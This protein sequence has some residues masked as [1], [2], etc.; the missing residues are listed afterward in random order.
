MVNATSSSS[1]SGE[2]FTRFS[3]RRLGVTR[4][5]VRSV[6]WNLDGRRLATGGQ[7]RSLRI[8][9]PEKDPRT[10]T[11][12]RG[13]QG[14]VSCVRW[15]PAHPERL[16]SCSASS[17]DKALHFWDIRQGS[18]PTSTVQT[19]GD[20]IT[21]T[22]SPDGKTIVLGN[23][24]DKVIWV[25]VEEQ[26]IVRTEDMAQ[27]TNEAVFSHNGS[28]LI[29]TIEGR[30]HIKSFPSNTP[31][32]TVNIS[33]FS[34]TVADLDPRG[35]YFAA[36]SNDATLTL[37]ETE[38]WTCASASGEHDEPVRVCKFSSDG[39]YVAS[40]ASDS[41]GIV[42]SEVPTLKKLH[43]IPNATACDSLAWHPT[44]NVLAYGGAEACIWGAG[45]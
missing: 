26:R 16:A 34:T 38:E 33:G 44:R 3:S 13:H 14:E 24:S 35:R 6:A 8:Y 19:F 2:D 4:E 23:R 7:D 5:R 45:V 11:E 40:S 41:S 27:E 12:C 28:L 31:V 1:S 39:N 29:T 32:H 21:M 20:N 36:G 43:S 30:A 37:W 9:L 42:I 22:W 10:S 17:T 18:K 25:D 15:S